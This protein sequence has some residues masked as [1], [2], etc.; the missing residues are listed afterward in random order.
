MVRQSKNMMTLFASKKWLGRVMLGLY[1][2]L[3]VVTA[4]HYHPANSCGDECCTIGKPD[5]KNETPSKDHSPSCP[6]CKF[7]VS[8]SE[9]TISSFQLQTVAHAWYNIITPEQPFLS[10][11]RTFNFSLRGPP[12]S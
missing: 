8:N 10:S 12:L 2:S 9:L 4:F 1:L 7:S 5:T 3:L 6:I 11:Q